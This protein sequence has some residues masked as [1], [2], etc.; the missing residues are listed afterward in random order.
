MAS[1][2]AGMPRILLVAVVGY[3][4]IFAAGVMTVD[5][6]LPDRVTLSAFGHYWNID[7]L[8]GRLFRATLLVGL[9]VPAIFVVE[10][11]WVGW[12]DCS[13]RHFFV[14]RSPSSLSDLV[15]FVLWRGHVMKILGTLL[16]FGAL[17]T[18]GQW[19]NDL[20]RDWTG[21]RLSLAGWPFAVQ[22]ICYVF[23]YTFL[24]YWNHRL[25]HTSYFWPLHRYH[26]SAREFYILT[27]TRVHPASFSDV[28]VFTLPMA[29]IGTPPGIVAGF[30]LVAASYG[31][32]IH[33]RI[34][35]DFGWVGRWIVQ[36]PAHHR[37]HHSLEISQGTANYSLI[38]LWDRLF[39]TWRDTAGQAPAVGV[40][41]PYRHGAWVFGDLL[42][43]YWDF[44]R[45]VGR[46]GRPAR[47]RAGAP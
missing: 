28:L 27:S 37:I 6:L 47:A 41:D 1:G 38:P 32:L 19:F 44:L 25:D 7:D 33:S 35:A 5:T 13:L 23:L 42:R 31:Y 15:T 12:Q 36:S 11:A 18:T 20:V 26:H 14:D 40:T 45:G 24:N 43:D 17:L 30:A 4:L 16:T 9:V 8:H 39:G 2:S 29:L 10:T 46:L 3:L 22:I 21:L 34:D